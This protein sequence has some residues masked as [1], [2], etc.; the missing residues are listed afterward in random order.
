M[1]TELEE[2][3]EFLHHGNTQIRQIAAENLVPYSEKEPSIFKTGQLTPIKDLKLLVKDYEPIAKNALTILINISNDREVL[4]NIIKDDAFLE[5]LLLRIT[6]PKE[7]NANE[8]AMLLANMAKSDHIKRILT[9]TRDIPKPL[10]TSKV[11]IDQL[12]DCFVKGAQGTYNPK[13][14]FDYLAYLFADIAKFPQGQTYFT[15]PAAY[16]SLLPLSKLTP[17]TTHTS[18]IRRKGVASTLKN[19]SFNIPSHRTLLS[20][21]ASD[22]NILVPIL[23]P[24]LGPEEFSLEENEQLPEELQFLGEDKRRDSD[25]ENLKTHLETLLL[26]TATREGRDELRGRGVY[27]VVRELHLAVEDEG[28]REACD[29]LV[30]VLMR[31]EEGEGREVDGEANGVVNGGRAIEEA[32]GRMV[33]QMEEEEDEQVVEIF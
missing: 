21:S 10:T 13:A 29:R 27:L 25:V 30:Q 31:D 22:A 19:V 17:F 20:Q 23:T 15:T 16:D 7:P 26:L 5:S 18:P 28:V 4:E 11:A 8:I 32:P 24:L 3:V 12:M 9:L 33:A 14:D 2:L 6:N 1:P